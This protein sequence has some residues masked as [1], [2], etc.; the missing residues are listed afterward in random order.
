MTFANDSPKIL[1]F[2]SLFFEFDNS[3]ER[4]CTKKT[5]MLMLSFAEQFDA[6]FFSCMAT[7]ICECVKK[8]DSIEG[9]SNMF[10]PSFSG[11]LGD[12]YARMSHV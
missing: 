3:G 10:F 9:E 6:F 7:N 5:R 11:P 12:C 4:E 2:S 1:L 8:C